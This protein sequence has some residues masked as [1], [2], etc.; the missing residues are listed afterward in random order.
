MISVI[1]LTHFCT[2]EYYYLIY[3]EAESSNAN[4]EEKQRLNSFV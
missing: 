3:A 2:Y 1:L 4:A